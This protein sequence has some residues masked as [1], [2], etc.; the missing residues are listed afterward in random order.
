MK[1]SFDKFDFDSSLGHFYSIEFNCPLYIHKDS[2]NGLNTFTLSISVNDKPVGNPLSPVFI[3]KYSKAIPK[4]DYIILN[5]IRP[6][7]KKNSEPGDMKVS[8]EHISSLDLI[9]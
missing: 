9:C 1:K 5:T 6:N 3:R 7:P 4:E 8:R 2:D